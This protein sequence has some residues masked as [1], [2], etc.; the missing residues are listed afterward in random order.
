MALV[1]ELRAAAEDAIDR[2]FAILTCVPKKKDPYS[3]Y[4]PH[5]INSASRIKEVALKAWDDGEEANYGVGCGPS[6]LTVLDADHG[7]N[8][9]EEFE[10]WKK[11]HNL[12]ETLT[13]KS[14]REGELGIHMYYLGAVNTCGLK[15]GKVVGELRGFGGYVVGPGSVHPSGN[16]YTIISDVSPVPLPDH[17][18]KIA[19]DKHKG[20]L[21]FKP[22]KGELIPEGNRWQHLQ[23]K[24]GTFKN[25]GLSE[26]GIYNALKDFCSQ[27]CENGEAYPDEKIRNLAQWAASDK[28]EGEDSG[29]ITFGSPDPEMESGIPHLPMMAIDGDWIGDLSLL[30]TNETFLPPSF[31][32]AT[33]K[34]IL[35]SV[36]DGY[37]GFPKEP[38]LHMRH[39]NAL[40]SS[41][42]GT[43]KSLTWDRCGKILNKLLTTHSVQNTPSGYFSSGEHAIKVLAE[44][45]GKPHLVY[46][47]E[48]KGLFDKGGNTGS[49]L[50]S[51]ILELYENKSAAIGALGSGKAGFNNVSLSMTGNFTRDGFNRSVSGKG[52]GGNGFLS[53]MVIDYSSGIDYTGDWG[54][55]DTLKIQ[56]TV[57]K[58]TQ[59]V[60]E[61]VEYKLN[62]P[63]HLPFI[64]EEDEET[65]THRYAFM[66]WLAGEQ[67][68]IQEENSEAS[69]A[70]RLDAHFKRDLLLRVLMTPERRITKK[71]IDRSWAWTRHQLML[72]ETLWPIDNGGAIEKFE[73]SILKGIVNNGPL[74][75]SGVQRFSNADKGEGG[76]DAWNRAWSNLLKADKVVLM[77]H[78]SDRGKEKFGLDSGIWDKGK[79]KWLFG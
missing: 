18:I 33:I 13:V 40:V 12:P 57:N 55:L 58:I 23:S 53:R 51:R 77:R 66:D 79:K 28:C 56:D 50:F 61:I 60:K 6:N 64:P 38:E 39:W 65:K 21:D 30:L 42:P 44:N 59:A 35:G 20:L 27:N 19:Q 73:K 9:L 24:A 49:T 7:L 52:A 17:L 69:Y 78:K 25:I 43:G 75:K 37:V 63:D 29:V 16:K 62:H 46:F 31:A 4:S 5:A 34:T 71:L 68:R 76:Y 22:G 36:L 45:D 72:R 47:D 54:D 32:R 10:A 67:K 48:M 2:G 26:D 3:K 14:G 74:T 11:E 41:R 8:T 70:T 1:D 15:L